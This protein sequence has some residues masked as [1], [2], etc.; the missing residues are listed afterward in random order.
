MISPDAGSS[1][2][3]GPVDA[4]WGSAVDGGPSYTGPTT[5]GTVTVTRATKMSPLGPGFAG[6]SFEKGHL[7]TGFFTG[8]NAPLIA[9]FNLLGPGVIRIGAND[10]DTHTWNPTAMPVPGGSMPPSQIGTADVDQLDAFLTATGWK[11]IYGVN[12]KAMMTAP[13]VAEAQYVTSKIGTKLLAFE[14]GNEISFYTTPQ[15]W[16]TFA[17]AIHAALPNAPLAGPGDYGSANLAVSFAQAEGSQLTMLT[18]HYYRASATSGNATMANLLAI[19]PA[20][21]SDSR[22]ISGAVSANHIR[23]GFRWGEMNSYSSH[24]AAGVSNAFGSALWSIDFMLNTA[25]YGSAGVNF[26]G[27]GEWMDNNPCPNGP[28][29]C[30][31]P[32][33]YSPIDEAS[34]Q[35]TAAAPLYYGMLF[36]S[37][38]GTGTMLATTATAGNLNF[39]A[40]SILQSDGSTNVALVNKDTTNGVNASIDVGAPVTSASAMY[41][42][43]PSLTATSGVTFA[44]AGV[45]PAGVWNQSPPYSLSKNGNVV[46]VVVPPASAALVHAQ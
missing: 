12:L 42:Q 17:T 21:A 46:T 6:F 43:A 16:A 37:H 2:D 4:G 1:F 34:G 45:T 7:A 25:Q 30:T 13:S 28:T 22:T 23:D 24:G 36:V 9:L 18:H 20:V 8:T 27:G 33:R 15:A 14:I 31:R 40:Y 11:V 29:S 39:S 19:D 3:A 26:H 41:L 44:G 10:V 5:P 35:V 38:A 32:F